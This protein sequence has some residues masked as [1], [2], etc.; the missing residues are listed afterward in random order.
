MDSILITGS[1]GF[2]SKNFIYFLI[3]AGFEIHAL[4]RNPIKSNF[5]D[6]HC[7]QVDITDSSQTSQIIKK[8][9]P[10]FLIHL[11][12]IV[13]HEVFWSS[14]KNIDYITA[15][16]NLYKE[17]S[18]Q[19]G[20]KAIFFGSCAEYEPNHEICNEEIT[21]LIPTTL[22]GLAKKQTFELL[23]QLKSLNPLYA[24]FVWIRIFNIF[25]LH[26]N[27]KRL[28]PYLFNTYLKEEVPTLNSPN[29]IRDFLYAENL[30]PII[31]QL[32]MGQMQGAVNIGQD[33]KLSIGE[34]ANLIHNRYFKHKLPPIFANS[35]KNIL[36]PCLKKLNLRPKISIEN[37][38]DKMYEWCC[39]KYHH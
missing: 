21:P 26:E 14:E 35:Q 23:T 13:E 38:L 9:K 12:W 36:L 15:T 33:I 6:I 4:S 39:S 2:L 30:G 29:A 11:A 19:G 31:E 10:I 1:T 22:Y 3:N 5:N 16:I 28:V 17:F 34:L 32:L 8:I 25:G 24:P 37:G 27:L 18:L 20:K 7:H